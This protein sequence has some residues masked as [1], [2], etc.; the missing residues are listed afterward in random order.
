MVE[1]V[2]VLK[3]HCY[4]YGLGT[5]L[6]DA[7]EITLCGLTLQITDVCILECCIKKLCQLLYSECSLSNP[8]DTRYLIRRKKCEDKGTYI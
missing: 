6:S 8:S 4:M 2:P 1:F 3:F 7:M 5:L